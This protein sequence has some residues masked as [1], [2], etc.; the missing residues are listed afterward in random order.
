[1]EK[2]IIGRYV[3]TTYNMSH[4]AFAFK[5]YKVIDSI[6]GVIPVICGETGDLVIQNPDDDIC[7]EHLNGSGKWVWTT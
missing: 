5:K 7:C 1:M 6:N 3:S 4:N 2:S